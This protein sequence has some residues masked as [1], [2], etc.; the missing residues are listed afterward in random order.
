MVVTAHSRLAAILSGPDGP[1]EP[2][3]S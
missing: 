1:R 2:S 3:G